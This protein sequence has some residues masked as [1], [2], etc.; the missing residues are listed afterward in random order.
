[1]YVKLQITIMISY[2][3]A[4]GIYS[5]TVQYILRLTSALA[6]FTLL[7]SVCRA[8]ITYGVTWE[9]EV[10]NYHMYIY[11]IRARDEGILNQFVKWVQEVKSIILCG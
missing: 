8:K 10:S 3:S 5:G 7:V 11:E 2:D 1:M 6:Q 4:A 9:Y